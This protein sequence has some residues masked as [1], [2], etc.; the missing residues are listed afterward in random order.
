[1]PAGTKI[2]AFSASK[3]VATDFWPS[4]APDT[5]KVRFRASGPPKLP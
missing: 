4:S 3:P 2:G 1:M 5:K